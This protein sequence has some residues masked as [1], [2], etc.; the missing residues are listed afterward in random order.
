[1][2]HNSSAPL[3]CLR[4]RIQH[5]LSRFVGE[6]GAFTGISSNI[7]APDAAGKLI[8][9]HFGNGVF[10]HIHILIINAEQSAVDSCKQF[11]FHFKFSLSIM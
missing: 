5:L 8:I 2:R 10:F 11:F 3:V 9:H 1:M 6:N 7:E 4:N